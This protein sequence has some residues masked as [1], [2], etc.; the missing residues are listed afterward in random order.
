MRGKWRWVA[1]AVLA[2]A[3]VAAAVY[4][5]GLRRLAGIGAG[6]VAKQGCSC[7]F[8][9]ERDLAACRADMPADMARVRAVVLRS[10]REVRAWVPLLAERTA[11]YR[12]GSGCTLY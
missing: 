7:V 6:Y 1:G 12:A 5:P 3:L 11:R 9:A 10:E 4:L 8:V 2:A